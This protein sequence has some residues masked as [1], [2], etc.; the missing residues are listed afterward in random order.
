[1]LLLPRSIS[2]IAVCHTF[3][4]KL[5]FCFEVITLL[6]MSFLVG[7]RRTRMKSRNLFAN[8]IVRINV[9]EHVKAFSRYNHSRR[10]RSENVSST[11]SLNEIFRGQNNRESKI[12]VQI[13]IHLS[14]S[15]SD[16]PF[17]HDPLRKI[18]GAILIMSRFAKYVHHRA[19][20][21]L[22]LIVSDR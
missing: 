16:S 11:G 22:W 15:P 19:I 10:A 3:V 7:H 6:E 12:I 9:E 4:R 18:D 1:M 13:N 8:F 21:S 5:Q 17:C 2:A 20:M 14:L